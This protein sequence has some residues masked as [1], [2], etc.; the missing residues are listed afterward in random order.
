MS[1]PKKQTKR[2]ALPHAPSA[3]P[4][5]FDR[6]RSIW[7]ESRSLAARSVNTAH[8]CANWLIGREIVEEEQAGK[9]RAD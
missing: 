7:E 6:V 2:V 3:A 9:E 8:V 4:A 1:A 5:L